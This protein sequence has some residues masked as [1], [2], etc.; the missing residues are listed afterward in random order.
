MLG[1]T[2]V[3]KSKP[4]SRVLDDVMNDL[5]WVDA[6]GVTHVGSRSIAPAAAKIEVLDYQTA[7]RVAVVASENPTEIAP[8]VSFPV[9][10]IG[11]FVAVTVVHKLTAGALR[12]EVYGA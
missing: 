2:Y 9:D 10:G 3:R 7:R 1:E 8:Y 6:A 4:A 12:T 5:W 11:T